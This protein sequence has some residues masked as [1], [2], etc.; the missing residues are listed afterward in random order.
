MSPSWIVCQMVGLE[1]FHEVWKMPHLN[2]LSSVALAC[3]LYLVI[4]QFPLE[5]K[6]VDVEFSDEIDQNLPCR[7][8]LNFRCFLSCSSSS[9]WSVGRG[10]GR[11]WRR[12]RPGNCPES[13]SS[14]RGISW[15]WGS[16]DWPDLSENRKY[17][18]MEVE[19]RGF[20]NGY[21]QHLWCKSIV[22]VGSIPEV[23]ICGIPLS[24]K[25]CLEDFLGKMTGMDFQDLTKHPL[26]I[27]LWQQRLHLTKLCSTLWQVLF[28]SDLFRR[29]NFS[30]LHVF[31][32][33]F[34][35]LVLLK[36]LSQYL[37]FVYSLSRGLG[38][39]GGN[40]LRFSCL[41]LFSR[42]GI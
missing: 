21:C 40:W 5:I 37:L 29:Y 2:F 35:C 24:Y 7:S 25:D 20:V 3:W 6:A 31:C 11:C 26:S 14:P 41:F 1:Q 18:E 19:W 38:I 34:T 30:V 23:T 4:S 33:V 13:C 32:L 28:S 36:S 39:C 16:R 17:L 22:D 10:R 8:L 15:I 42:L 12:P 9:T 27:L